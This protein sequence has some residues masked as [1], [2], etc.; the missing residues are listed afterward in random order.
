MTHAPTFRPPGDDLPGMT[1]EPNIDLAIVRDQHDLCDRHPE[2]ANLA[3]QRVTVIATLPLRLVDFDL[4]AFCAM[5]A[6]AGGLG[7]THMHSRHLVVDPT[8]T[9][10][11][12]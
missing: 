12:S 9:G 6:R 10:G 5:A 7:G 11:T 2:C 8:T 4:C 1:N 3:Q